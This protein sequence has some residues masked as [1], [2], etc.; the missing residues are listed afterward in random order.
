VTTN[1]T[2][3]GTTSWA[4]WSFTRSRKSRGT[5]V[6]T[7]ARATRSRSPSPGGP[8]IRKTWMRS[9]DTVNASKCSTKSALA[10][11]L[12]PGSLV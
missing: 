7:S 5:N 8:T 6:R 10:S 9:R 12:L 1:A 11:D 4:A 3:C 2:D